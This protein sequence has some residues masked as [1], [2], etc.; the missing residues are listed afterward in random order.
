MPPSATALTAAPA[1][2]PAR[3][4]WLLLACIAAY[5]FA[6]VPL[7]LLPVILSDSMA[8]LQLNATQ[9]GLVVSGETLGLGL[10]SIGLAAH[11]FGLRY[12]TLAWL[13]A[14]VGLAG[15]GLSTFAGSFESLVAARWVAGAGEG[16]VLMVA[17]ALV[18]DFDDPERAYGTLNFVNILYGSAVFMAM[19]WAWPE[20][21]GLQVFL[22]CTVAMVPLLLPMLQLSSRT[23]AVHQ[24]VTEGTGGQCS[25][26]SRPA[27]LLYLC[28]LCIGSSSGGTW[29]FL[30]EY[31]KQT[32]LAEDAV[33]AAIGVATLA[34]IVGSVLVGAVGTRWGRLLPLLLGVLA[35]GAA[36]VLL[37]RV[38]SPLAFRIEATVT[39]I[40]IYFLLPGLLA[41]GA[42]LD[43][44][45]RISTVVGGVFMLTIAVGP[46]VFGIV[47]D[48]A[49]MAG[50]SP[51]V[52][53][54]CGAAFL[55]LCGL[56]RG[57]SQRMILVENN[58]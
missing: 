4:R 5:T 7:W 26:L 3:L 46:T 31:G 57:V 30:A 10:V 50:L 36:N 49:G 53:L 19:P 52:L 29:A 54:L 58:A 13:G 18:A 38:A 39:L 12:R 20:R 48:H 14:V 23:A 16:A 9:A 37:T 1:P 17:T 24:Q 22:V 2:T 55:L 28:M 25:V 21:H 45:G 51:A 41:Y 11:S 47:V 56:H 32:G 35:T 40:S 44:T 33:V 6:N 15:N 34:A 27:L 43:R 8:T 42:F